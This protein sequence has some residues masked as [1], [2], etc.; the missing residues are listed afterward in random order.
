MERRR[1][2]LLALAC[3]LCLIAGAP[4][5][6]PG[7][8]GEYLVLAL[9]FANFRGP[10]ID[11]ADAPAL[12]R[13]SAANDA[14]LESWDV[15]SSTH[16]SPRSGHDFLHFWVY[17]LLATPGVWITRAVGLAPGYAFAILNLILLLTALGVA[18]PRVGRAAALL[19]F[20]G[21]IIWWIDK[22]HTEPFT[23]ALVAIA[24]LLFDERPWWSFVAAGL[25]TTQNLPIGMLL[26]LLI[27]W[28]ALSHRA[29]LVDRR[30]QAGVAV[31]FALASLQPIYMYVRHGVVSLLLHG[32]TTRSPDL[33]EMASTVVDPSIGLIWN[34]PGLAIGVV[35][36]LALLAIRRPRGI[37][38]ADVVIA[39]MA[40]LVFLPAFAK[41]GNLHHGATPSLSRYTLWLVPLTLPLFRHARDAAGRGWRWSFTALAVVS[42]IGSVF[43]YHP[44]LRENARE[45]TWAASWLWRSHPTWHN[46]LPEIF[47]E[48]LV[49]EERLL[50]PAFTEDCEKILTAGRGDVGVWPIPCY[51]APL[52]ERCTI[53]N[54]FCYANRT[55]SGYVFADA[56]GSPPGAGLLRREVVWPR[57][58]EAQIRAILDGWQWPRLRVNPEAGRMWLRQVREVR[59]SSIG[60]DRRVLYVLQAPRAGAGLVFRTPSPVRG[61]LIDPRTG[62][63]LRDVDFSGAPGEP[64]FL[65]VPDSG[66]LLVLTLIVGAS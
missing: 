23:F 33:T 51:P 60:D 14:R 19:V 55:P 53:V 34:F 9:N 21:P 64:W 65:A 40:A 58:A 35:S 27:L 32:A 42:A 20:A 15:L 26:V 63:V 12:A 18:L 3:A 22:P 8:G 44:R 2:L 4:P 5:Q 45:P 61:Q 43:T 16:A 31:S 46:P 48:T 62:R 66:D 47:I 54:A 39:A 1:D 13:E 6:I 10:A 28:S 59:V 57:E 56:P 30:W 24:L 37:V 29:H 11:P 41:A 38:S 49:R 17:P 50:V 52:P 7:D 25:A 36:A